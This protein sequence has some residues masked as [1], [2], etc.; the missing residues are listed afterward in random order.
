MTRYTVVHTTHDKRNMTF[1]IPH[2]K[3]DQPSIRKDGPKKHDHQK[4]N[5][6]S[7]EVYLRRRRKQKYKWQYEH[8]W[9]RTVEK[10]MK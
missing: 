1:G 6:L 10:R 3:E 4:M 5:A 9:L 2:G 7:R 8:H